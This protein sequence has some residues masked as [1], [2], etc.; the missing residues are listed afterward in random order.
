MKIKD[1]T[2]RL[3]KDAS[4]Y[5]GIS[6]LVARRV[7]ILIV[8]LYFTSFLFTIGGFY[9]PFLSLESISMIHF[10]LFSL[11][12]IA[13]VWFGYSFAEYM[14]YIYAPEKRWI[15]PGVLTLL[16]IFGLLVLFV[17]LSPLFS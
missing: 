4:E 7:F 1:I 12:V 10:H 16:G 14:S 17:H 6:F 11:L 13:V 3:H 15:P 9:L 2:E 8:A 5:N